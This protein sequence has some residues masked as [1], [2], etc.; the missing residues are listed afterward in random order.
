MILPIFKPVVLIILDGVGIAQNSKGNAVKQAKTPFLESAW[1]SYPHTNLQASGRS[2]GLPDGVKGNS[3][4]GHLN[5]GGG[6]IVYQD[7]PRIDQSIAIGSFCNNTEF[8]N[9]FQHAKKHNSRI[10]VALCFSNGKVHSSIDHLKAFL[11][12]AKE[13]NVKQPVIINAFTDGRDSPPKSAA[14]FLNQIDQIMHKTGIGVYGSIIGRYFAMDRNQQWDRTRKAYN[15]LTQGVGDKAMNWKTAIENAYK[16]GETDEF[17]SPII[18]QNPKVDPTVKDG[19]SFIFLN[20]RADRAIQIATAFVKPD[21]NHFERPQY[22]NNLYFLGMT[23]YAK[24]IPEHVAFQKN[25][26]DIPLG[27][28]ISE[29]GKRQLRIAESEKFPHVTYFFNG[30]R[31]IKFEGEDR[32]EVPSP[33]V[34]TYDLQPEMSLFEVTEIITQKIALNIYDF[35]LLNIANGDMV[36]HTGNLEAGVLAMEVVDRCTQKIAKAATAFGGAALITADHGNIEEMINLESQQIDTEH[37]YN[38]VPFIFVPPKNFT[39]KVTLSSG[40]LADIS[41]T[42]LKLMGI[43]KPSSMVRQSLI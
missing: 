5:I 15:A 2:V 26:I 7:L 32:V 19:D 21:F 9:A 14:I 12:C 41:P 16:K 17:I 3:E 6:Q 22:L 18:I 33:K 8:L 42:I 31:S 10:H 25:K 38:P 1:S 28:Q 35:I 27:R 37:S 24:G 34:A 20:Y 43:T 36:G 23:P 4:V 30:G 29:S 11:H 39:Q 13:N 40:I